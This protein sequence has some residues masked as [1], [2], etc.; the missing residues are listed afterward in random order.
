MVHEKTE[1]GKRKGGGGGGGGGQQ[2]RGMVRENSKGRELVGR[3]RVRKG[4]CTSAIM[5]EETNTVSIEGREVV[6]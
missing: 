1:Q 5:R 2:G 3:R 6:T 4:R